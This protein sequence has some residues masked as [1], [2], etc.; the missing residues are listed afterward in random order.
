[1]TFKGI[2]QMEF[3]GKTAPLMVF[4]DGQYLLY[5]HFTSEAICLPYVQVFGRKDKEGNWSDIIYSAVNQEDNG[6]SVSM[7]P[8]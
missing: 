7:G 3:S 4:I 2:K 1:M 8:P 5:D 6:L